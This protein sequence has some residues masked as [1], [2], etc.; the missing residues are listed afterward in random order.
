MRTRF[1]DLVFSYWGNLAAI[2]AANHSVCGRPTHHLPTLAPRRAL[3][4]LGWRYHIPHLYAL[5]PYLPALRRSR[6]PPPQRTP[7]PPRHF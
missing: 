6:Q 3:P 2:A 5:A 4:T 1:S 7:I